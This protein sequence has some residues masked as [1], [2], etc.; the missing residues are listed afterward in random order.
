LSINDVE[1]DKGWVTFSYQVVGK[2]TE[3]LSELKA[4]DTLDVMGPL[5]QGFKTNLSGKRVGL[6]GGG[7]GLAPLIFLGRELSRE[8]QVQAFWGVRSRELLPKFATGGNLNFPY[9]VVTEDGSCGRLGLV[10]EILAE[11]IA[12][13]IPE[14]FDFLFA[15][16]PGP[17]LT[18]VASLARE[19]NIPLQVSLESVMACGVGACLGCTIKGRKQ[20]KETQFKVCQDGPVFWAEEVL[21]NE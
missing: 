9:T 19:Y 5:G 13:D 1:R 10:T 12:R 18:A 20:G 6:I 17:M 11:V 4:G 7:M 15:C 8:N 16:G 2:G 21:G 14:S 3:L